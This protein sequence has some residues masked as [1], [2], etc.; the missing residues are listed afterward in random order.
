MMK[1]KYRK[2]INYSLIVTIISMLILL[3]V[4]LFNKLY[5]EPELEKIEE[6]L[7]LSQQ[8]ENFNAV[9]KN[10]YLSAQL[11]LQNYILTKDTVFLN[12]YNYHLNELSDN[13]SKLEQIV[14][15]SSFLKLHL[16]HNIN[17]NISI[18]SVQSKI[19]SITAI[20]LPEQ[21]N[22]NEYRFKTGKF[23]YSNIIDSI[24]I[25]KNTTVDSIKKKGFFAR[26]G[27][28]ISGNV[29]VQKE[30]ENVVVTIGKNGKIDQLEKQFE[31]LFNDINK[32][33]ANEF[34][35]YK[36]QYTLEI[37]NTQKGEN[38]FIEANKQ[39]LTYGSELLEHYNEALVSFTKNT[40]EKFAQQSKYDKEIK[41]GVV[42]GLIILMV[43][44]AI[45]LI[46]V[47]RMSFIYEER[48]EKA[49]Q[50]ISQ[51]LNFKNRIVGMIS[52]E[53]RAPLNIIS[54]YTKG[55]RRRVED[56]NVKES[57]KSIEFTTNSLSLLSNQILEYSKNQ[58]K[59]LELK[60][61][62]FNVYTQLE[63]IFKS[64]ESLVNENG[65]TLIVNNQL[66][67]NNTNVYSDETKIHQLFYNLV[68]NANKFT[69]NGTIKIKVESENINPKKLNL[70]VTI[71]DTGVGINEND[72]QHIFTEYHQGTV[73]DKMKN[74]GVGLGLNLSREII[75]LYNGNINVTSTKGEGTIVQFNL[76]LSKNNAN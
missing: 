15:K 59:K 69:T 35:K 43:V 1:F 17:D 48:L 63:G 11:N 75:E 19:D 46:F 6:D 57:L 33:Y 13:L 67:L 68:G 41:N 25:Q 39:L 70:L 64:L 36:K 72:I 71:Q 29:E 32:Y 55:I 52:H 47:T 53:I 73:S 22:I 7:H 34:N 27:D 66:N 18:R 26:V 10:S 4:L 21:I 38:D 37:A 14:N 8:I 20:K 65:N 49:K 62:E 58:N 56:E 51:N 28:A 44:I 5:N 3:L 16:K 12:K 74:M 31:E 60:P 42:I 2:I 45:L 24:S 40:R 23:D 30:K 54:I 9:T 50:T 61:K 76:E